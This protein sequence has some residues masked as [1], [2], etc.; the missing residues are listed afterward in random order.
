MTAGKSLR[1]G[2]MLVRMGLCWS[3]G[4]GE[5]QVLRGWCSPPSL[6][7]QCPL[8]TS[9]SLHAE[10]VDERNVVRGKVWEHTAGAGGTL[11]TCT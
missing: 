3:A 10:N 4:S 2:L 6:D 7:R 8:G 9:V 11:A 1:V 5:G